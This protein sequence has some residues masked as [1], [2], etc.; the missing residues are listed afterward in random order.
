MLILRAGICKDKGFTFFELILAIFIL[1]ML[2]V[3]AMPRFSDFGED[4]VKSESKRV[5]SILRY[6]Y[7]SA[8]STKDT[9]TM[10]ID[11]KEGIVIYTCPEG[12]KVETIKSLYALWLQSKGK[13]TEG[14]VTIFFNPFGVSEAMI[15][16]MRGEKSAMAVSMNPLSGRVKIYEE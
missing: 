2:A 16:H 9:F 7:D 8:T 12:T 4:K 5:A 13:V 10:K 6:L 1:S 15:F 3:L 11:F 14:E